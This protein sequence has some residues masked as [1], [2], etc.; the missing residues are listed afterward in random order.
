[1]GIYPNPPYLYLRCRKCKCHVNFK[2]DG[3]EVQISQAQIDHVHNDAAAENAEILEFMRNNASF[4]RKAC[5]M[6]V[7]N[8]FPIKEADTTTC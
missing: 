2:F 6:L 1:M 4:D 3:E 5:K 7:L 8:R